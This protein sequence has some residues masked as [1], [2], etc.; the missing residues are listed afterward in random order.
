MANQLATEQ[1]LELL[2]QLKKTTPEAA[3]RILNDRPPIAYAL[4]TLMVS[5]NAINFDVFQK[6]LS[7]FGAANAP[8]QAQ[9]PVPAPA[10]LS[11]VPPH[12]QASSQPN[13]RT[14]TPPMQSPYHNPPQGAY[15][16]PPAQPLPNPPYSRG[17]PA[18]YSGG[19]SSTPPPNYGTPPP[20][21]APAV[22]D[23][24]AAFP[25]EQRQMIM[26]VLAMTPEQINNLPP[27]DRANIMQLRA[28]LGFPH[29]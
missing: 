26:G 7:E 1:L 20:L 13:S 4:I 6:T 3:R 18:G 29:V 10:P 21:P 9:A 28:T 25:E 12:L 11:A 8:P 16:Y 24:L 27:S 19:F 15:G 14:N 2:L 22:A 5:M 17:P 23:P